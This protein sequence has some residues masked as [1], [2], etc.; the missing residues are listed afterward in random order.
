MTE[1]LRVDLFW[2]GTDEAGCHGDDDGFKRWS[3]DVLMVMGVETE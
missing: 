2:N 3:L 1:L